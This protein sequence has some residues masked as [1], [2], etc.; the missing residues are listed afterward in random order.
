M[1]AARYAFP[2]LD[3]NLKD[4]LSTFSGIRAVVDTGKKDPSKESREHV[5]WQE[6][7]LVTVTGGKLTT[8]RVMAHDAMRSIRHRLPGH[9]R[10]HRNHRMLDHPPVEEML[11]ANLDAPTALRLLGRYGAHAVSI[12]AAA[13]EG[14]L[15]PIGDTTALWAELRW[16][17]RSEAVLHLDDLLLRRLRLGIIAPQGG[18]PWLEKIREIAQPELGWDDLRWEQEAEAYIQLWQQ[19]YS[20]PTA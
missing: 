10:L 1:V 19:S 13:R 17:A 14:E 5:I 12:V 3:L 6:G 15:E 9:P 8:F 18:I 11:N 2:P 7:G 4:V 20:L 16:A